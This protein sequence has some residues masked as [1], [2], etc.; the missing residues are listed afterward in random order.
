MVS[1]LVCTPTARLKGR[2]RPRKPLLAAEPTSSKKI[3]AG[4][5]RAASSNSSR[6]WRSASPTHLLS[7]SAPLRMKNDTF[8]PAALEREGGAF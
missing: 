7:R 8:W 3:I 2:D 5:C 1:V 6:S 4:C